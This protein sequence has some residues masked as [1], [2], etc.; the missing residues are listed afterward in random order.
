[1]QL[2]RFSRGH[3][4]AAKFNDNP[5]TGVKLFDYI[6]DRQNDVA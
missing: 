1:M 5:S 4:Y 2:F 3:E 6:L